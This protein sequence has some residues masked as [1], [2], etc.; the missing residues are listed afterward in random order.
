MRQA[1]ATIDQLFER[2]IDEIWRPPNLPD[3]EPEDIFQDTMDRAYAGYEQKAGRQQVNRAFDN[4][5]KQSGHRN[6]LDAL[7]EPEQLAVVFGN[8]NYQVENGGFTQWIDNNYYED[9]IDRL[10]EFGDRFKER[11]PVLGRVLAIID[12]L[13]EYA[14][15]FGEDM[16]LPKLTGREWDEDIGN[17]FYDEDWD[18]LNELTGGTDIDKRR[19]DDATEDVLKDMIELS[20]DESETEGQFYWAIKRSRLH[21]HDE[22]IERSSMTYADEDQAYEAGEKR[23]EE[24]Q[25][26]A[27]EE[28]NELYDLA[29]EEA[30]NELEKELREGLDKDVHRTFER[31]DHDYYAI[32]TEVLDA[33]S[34]ILR[35]E[36]NVNSSFSQFFTQAMGKVRQSLKRVADVARQK[37]SSGLG[38]A[39]GALTR[40]SQKVRPGESAEESAKD[41]ICRLIS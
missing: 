35:T 26:E 30:K 18:R 1:K 22:E 16:T 19:V 37:L 40:A 32:H 15:N 24:L 11:F 8:L 25:K 14:S 9:T 17:A 39:A 6:F 41:S 5:E 38:R 20:V 33:I 10:R 7:A 34:S 13:E 27:M 23:A 2:Q 31:A 4:R 28:Q 3:K 21:G 29:R 12:E 36:Y